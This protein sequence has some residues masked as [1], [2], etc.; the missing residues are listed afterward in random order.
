M[1]RL[2][3]RRR[4]SQPRPA[5]S[6]RR[7]PRR[8]SSRSTGLDPAAAAG[9]AKDEEWGKI[10]GADVAASPHCPFAVDTR[11]GRRGSPLRAVSRSGPS[12]GLGH[13]SPGSFR[14]ADAPFGFPAGSPSGPKPW[15]FAARQHRNRGSGS[16]RRL[17]SAEASVPR[18]GGS[19]GRSPRPAW[20][21]GTEVPN[22]PV[23]QLPGGEARSCPTEPAPKRL[24]RRWQR[25]NLR[26]ASAGQSPDRNPS[27]VCRPQSPKA[28]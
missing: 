7:G 12:R 26:S 8:R 9:P 2:P 14:S 15:R 11:P 21:A 17:S 27:P 3:R 20:Q 24:F 18:A 1:R 22:L 5:R 28:S 23:S 13:G 4:L 19:S 10:M 16:R 6:S 25:A